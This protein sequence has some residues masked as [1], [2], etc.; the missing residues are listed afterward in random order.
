MDGKESQLP[1]KGE[2]Y[3]MGWEDPVAAWINQKI[4]DEQRCNGPAV[5]RAEVRTVM[6]KIPFQVVKDPRFA[7]CGL[8]GEWAIARGDIKVLMLFRDFKDIV[9][10]VERDKDFFCGEWRGDNAEQ[11][12]RDA[13]FESMRIIATMRI[14]FRL[15]PFP[16]ILDNFDLVHEALCFLGLDFDL[17]EGR[18][19]WDTLVDR[20]QVSPSV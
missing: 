1:G 8:I 10:S 7:F 18:K 16:D 15:L 4:V 6:R 3:I 5:D 2:K 19:I 20:T 11:F 12:Y 13:F 9:A 14:P 17:E